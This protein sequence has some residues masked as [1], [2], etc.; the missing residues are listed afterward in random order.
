MLLCALQATAAG[1]K[2]TEAV[3]MLEKKFKTGPQY[4]QK[5]VVELAIST[6]QVRGLPVLP[7]FVCLPYS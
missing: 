4:S 2:E 3:N 5:E 1:V 6:L 7:F